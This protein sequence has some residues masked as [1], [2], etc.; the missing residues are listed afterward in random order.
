MPVTKRHITDELMA[1]HLKDLH[2]SS[3]FTA[4]MAADSQTAGAG[5]AAFA[6]AAAAAPSASSMDINPPETSYRSSRG[7]ASMYSIQKDLQRKLSKAQRITLCDE[8]RNIQ[9]EAPL[10]ESLLYHRH[11]RPCN[12]LVLWQPPLISCNGDARLAR[13]SQPSGDNQPVEQN[14]SGR[15]TPDAVENEML[16]VDEDNGT[17]NCIGFMD[18]D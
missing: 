4:H 5:E 1:Q 14:S 8:I 2:I 7:G 12:A 16:C 11:E 18:L 6:A 3:Q 17:S 9:S 15:S 10:P 13:T